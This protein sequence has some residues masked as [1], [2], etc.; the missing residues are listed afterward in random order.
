MLKSIKRKINK[1]PT[2][3]ASTLV[4]EVEAIDSDLA[5]LLLCG[6]YLGEGIFGFEIAAETPAVEEYVITPSFFREPIG[7]EVHRDFSYLKNDTTNLHCYN[8]VLTR[9]SFLPLFIQEP[10]S[11]LDNLKRLCS[12]HKQMYIQLLFTKRTDKWKQ[13]FV[14]QYDAY[15]E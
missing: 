7:E 15:M 6:N 12:D 3:N 10:Y 2:E 5:T 4:Y 8:V 11:V 13:T 9:P 14:Q 1:T